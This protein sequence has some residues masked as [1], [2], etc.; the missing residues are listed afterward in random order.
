MGDE[1]QTLKEEIDQL[2]LILQ[3][4]KSR[5]DAE[6]EQYKGKDEETSKIMKHLAITKKERGVS[7]YNIIYIPILCLIYVFILSTFPLLDD[8]EARNQILESKYRVTLE[9]IENMEAD[10]SD[11]IVVSYAVVVVAVTA[12]AFVVVVVVVSLIMFI[13]SCLF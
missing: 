6:T 7:L 12:A 5:Y 3:E 13:V 4:K 2:N 11:M 1:N 8:C 10:H 9:R